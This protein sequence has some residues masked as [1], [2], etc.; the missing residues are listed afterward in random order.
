MSNL[1]LSISLWLATDDYQYNQNPYIISATTL[2]KPIKALV[3][4]RKVDSPKEV[5]L[6]SMIPSRMGTAIHTAIES[7]WLSPKTKE[8]LRK[9]GYPQSLVDRIVINPSVVNSDQIP[10]YLEQRV[11]KKLGEYTISGQYDFVENGVLEDFKTT[12]TVT[13]IT[14]SNANKY[15]LQA[16][17]YRWLNPEVINQDYMYIRYIFTDWSSTKAKQDSTYPQSRIISQRYNL[18]S[19]FETESFIENRISQLKINLNKPQEELP[20]CTP[21]ELW[22]KPAVFKYYK[23]PSNKTR[24]TK[25]FDTYY[26]AHA[27]WLE[28]QCVGE[29]VEVPGSV[30]FCR[31]CEGL[32]ICNQ[33]QN[34]L[35]TGLLSI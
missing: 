25:N 16:S 26:E 4:S 19:L 7:A 18:M 30:V 2:L 23:N 20:T 33:G 13:W 1:P 32:P 3:L 29:I 31:Y 10:I 15:V 5:N 34:Y 11:H 14:Q 8:R 21:D 28:D 22:Q 35:S 9:L 17:I 6:E 24:S 12:S 27:K